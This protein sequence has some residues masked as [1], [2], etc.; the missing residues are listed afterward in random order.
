[1]TEE[2]RGHFEG[3]PLFAG[4]ASLPLP[5]EDH[6]MVWH[7]AR[8]LREHR[9]DGHIAGLVIEGLGPVDALVIHAAM[10][11]MWAD[12]LRRSRHWPKADWEASIVSL[13]RRGWLTDDEAPT[14][15]PDGQARRAWIEDRTN[16][17][18][19]LAFDPI[20][21]AGVE[22]MIELGATYS[23]A[24]EA[25]GLGSALMAAIPMGD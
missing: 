24:L 8:L 4:L 15:T 9:G 10:L 6:L 22:R 7:A 23:A 17:L 14:F 25:A 12:G 13:R 1:V 18:A 5:D 2:A 20:G 21:P 11:P 3:R 16:Q 19:A